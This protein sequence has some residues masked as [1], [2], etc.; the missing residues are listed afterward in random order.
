MRNLIPAQE[1]SAAFR[2]LRERYRRSSLAST[3]FLLGLADE[4]RADPRSASALEA[5]QAA[6]HRMSGSAGSFG[7][8]EASRLATRLE[9]RVARWRS[10]PALDGERRPAMIER[11]VVG[12]RIA[13]D[14]AD[15]PLEIPASWPRVLLVAL[16]VELEGELV[17]EGVLHAYQVAAVGAEACT[18]VSLGVL[19]P[20]VIV[21]AADPPASIAHDVGARCLRLVAFRGSDGTA[22]LRPA[23][24]TSGTGVPHE[25]ADGADGGAD[26]VLE[27]GGELEALFEAAG[28]LIRAA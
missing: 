27:R 18:P 7:F 9:R 11:L 26:W 4:L 21:T 8:P 20:H 24:M 5:L 15:V 14:G 12:V 2:A 23:A 16:P 13:F 17:A 1:T 19:A 22:R 25:T 10:D 6:L 28:A 3:A